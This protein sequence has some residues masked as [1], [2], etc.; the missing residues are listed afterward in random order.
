MLAR[1]GRDATGSQAFLRSAS[2]TVGWLNLT[3]R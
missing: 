3:A 2:V 1:E